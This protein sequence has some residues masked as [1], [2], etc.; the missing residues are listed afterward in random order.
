MT[1]PRAI[2]SAKQCMAKV[3]SRKELEALRRDSAAITADYA[4]LVCA[5]MKDE[6]CFSDGWAVE[7]I[8]QIIEAGLNARKGIA[9]KL[10]RMGRDGS[11]Y[12]I[13]EEC[14]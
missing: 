11:E 2:E 6:S 5:S 8:A 4:L 1:D 12:R 7:F 14:E 9:E 13:E 10:G 3:F